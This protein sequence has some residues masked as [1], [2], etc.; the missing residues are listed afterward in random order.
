[1][2]FHFWHTDRLAKELAANSMSER[3]AC[4]YTMLGTVIYTLTTYTSLWF[5]AMRDWDFFFELVFVLVVSLVGVR[6]CYKANGGSE[7]TQFITRSSVLSVPIGLKL[8][9]AGT[10]L[11]QGLY[12]AAPY[13]FGSS[14]LRDPELVYR[15]ISFL[16]PVAFTFIFYWRIA[17]HLRYVKA[18]AVSEA[19]SAL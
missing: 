7:G 9:L 1:M 6:E 11:G 18:T 10:A 5:G 8:A 16:V 17:H 19:S 14:V 13:F 2:S 15:Y 4:Q 12:F 3:S